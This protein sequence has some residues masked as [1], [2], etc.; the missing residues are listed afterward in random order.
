[1]GFSKPGKTLLDNDIMRYIDNVK[2]LVSRECY[3]VGQIHCRICTF[4]P[5]SHLKQHGSMVQ[6]NNTLLTL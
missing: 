6:D 3:F 4:R 5:A 2:T 1:M